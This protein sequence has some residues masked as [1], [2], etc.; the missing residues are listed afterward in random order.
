M[1]QITPKAHETVNFIFI[2]PKVTPRWYVAFVMI[3]SAGEYRNI[4]GGLGSK[5]N[6]KKE[7]ERNLHRMQQLMFMSFGQS[8]WKF[9]IFLFHLKRKI[10]DSL[11]MT[12]S[13]ATV[14]VIAIFQ[15][16]LADS[17]IVFGNIPPERTE[18]SLAAIQCSLRLINHRRL[19]LAFK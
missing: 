6:N 5:W 15:I 3:A 16:G 14:N 2:A 13:S 4:P 10:N 19:Q 18:I 11:A 9:Y 17:D 12:Q 8:Y 1:S 7:E